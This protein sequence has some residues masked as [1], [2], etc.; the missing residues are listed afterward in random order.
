MKNGQIFRARRVCQTSIGLII[1]GT[2][3]NSSR[4]SLIAFVPKNCVFY[5][6]SQPDSGSFSEKILN[7]KSPSSS[8]SKVEGMTT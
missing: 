2:D 8:G 3:A 1:K 7:K 6:A 4:F 5:K